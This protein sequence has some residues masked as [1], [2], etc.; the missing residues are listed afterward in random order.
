MKSRFSR[1][2]QDEYEEG[3]EGEEGDCEEGIGEEREIRSGKKNG[4]DDGI[5]DEMNEEMKEEDNVVG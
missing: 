3:E 1:Q 4:S 2:I 5:I